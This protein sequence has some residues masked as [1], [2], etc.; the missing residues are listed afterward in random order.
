MNNDLFLY[1]TWMEY[2]SLKKTNTYCMVV[3]KNQTPYFLCNRHIKNLRYVDSFDLIVRIYNCFPI[4]FTTQ[5]SVYAQKR[6]WGNL[7]DFEALMF[8]T[9]GQNWEYVFIIGIDKSSNNLI[10]FDPFV[11][12][13]KPSLLYKMSMKEGCQPSRVDRDTYIVEPHSLEELL[14]AVLIEAKYIKELKYEVDVLYDE[15]AYVDSIK[16]KKGLSLY[17]AWFVQT[18]V[19]NQPIKCIVD[20]EKYVIEDLLLAY[21]DCQRSFNEKIVYSNG[22]DIGILI[23][24]YWNEKEKLNYTMDVIALVTDAKISHTITVTGVDINKDLILYFDSEQ[25]TLLTPEYMPVLTQGGFVYNNMFAI[26]RTDFIKIVY[27]IMLPE[28]ENIRD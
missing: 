19:M 13:H 9:D 25:N 14:F 16:N 6:D 22:K 7:A 28:I 15:M 23:F 2:L 3:G 1:Q 26:L 24:Q 10:C 5:R 18:V 27:A 21:P 20:S 12:E 17:E 8:I 4:K 11:K